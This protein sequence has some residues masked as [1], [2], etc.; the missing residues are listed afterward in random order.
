MLGSDQR[1][2]VQ[3]SGWDHAGEEKVMPRAAQVRDAPQEGDS[4]LQ[5]IPREGRACCSHTPHA[6]HFRP[7][8]KVGKIA[9]H[10]ETRTR[11]ATHS[12]KQLEQGELKHDLTC[13]PHRQSNYLKERQSPTATPILY[14]HLMSNH[15]QLDFILQL[16]GL[17]Q[18]D[19]NHF[20]T[21]QHQ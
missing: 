19:L 8:S 5:D 20:P 3:M 13:Y 9:A 11:L 21:K 10:P 16:P 4:L 2:T 18:R 6:E 12:Q 17:G 15:P 1:P 7:H 14:S